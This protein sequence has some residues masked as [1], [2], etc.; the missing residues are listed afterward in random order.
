[1]PCVPE[2]MSVDFVSGHKT[3]SFTFH[4]EIE[5]NINKLFLQL[6]TISCYL[7]VSNNKP[8]QS[9]PVAFGIIHLLAGATWPW[10]SDSRY[11][12]DYLSLPCRGPPHSIQDTGF[13][14]LKMA[15]Y[16]GTLLECTSSALHKT[17]YNSSLCPNA[18]WLDMPSLT[19][20]S[21]LAAPYVS[22][23]ASHF[24]LIAHNTKWLSLIICLYVDCLFSLL[25]I[26]STKSGNMSPLWSLYL[27]YSEKCIAQWRCSINICQRNKEASGLIYVEDLKWKWNTS[28]SFRD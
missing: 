19:T 11:S 4:D 18:T 15:S 6:C 28:A 17:S 20:Q 3:W 14:F 22:D 24:F 10:L 21:W 27:Q 26:S 1:M 2:I 8:F 23:T 25:N 12:Y 5:A 9:L 7:R 13:S 16:H